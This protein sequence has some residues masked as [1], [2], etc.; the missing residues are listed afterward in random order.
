MHDRLSQESVLEL[1]SLLR[2]ME[3]ARRERG[4]GGDGD[5]GEGGDSSSSC[6]HSKVSALDIPDVI[7]P[8]HSDGSRGKESLAATVS[9]MNSDPRGRRVKAVSA[10]PDL[11]EFRKQQQS[12]R[13]AKEVRF[14]ESR[15]LA[16]PLLDKDEDIDVQTPPPSSRTDPSQRVGGRGRQGGSSN[17]SSSSGSEG[18]SVPDVELF[19]KIP[20]S[21]GVTRTILTGDPSSE[22]HPPPSASPIPTPIHSLPNGGAEM[23]SQD[24]TRDVSPLLVIGGDCSN[25]DLDREDKERE[26]ESVRVRSRKALTVVVRENS[27]SPPQFCKVEQRVAFASS[28]YSD[29]MTSA[30]QTSTGSVP[31]GQRQGGNVNWSAVETLLDRDDAVSAFSIVVERGELEDLARVMQLLGPRPHV[32]TQLFCS[33]FRNSSTSHA[34]DLSISVKQFTNSLSVSLVLGLHSCSQCR[35]GTVFTTASRLC[36][37]NHMYWMTGA[38]T[39]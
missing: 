26:A 14:F 25:P 39:S 13:R 15:G 31:C 5:R 17:S 36:L 18:V 3:N 4:G 1:S 22:A 19:Q 12:L 23:T 6:R 9:I 27:E 7:S 34:V 11:L 8:K 33:F 32:R 30:T 38:A 28:V 21:K 24:E 2:S 37:R 10:R 20:N 35:L 16:D 29:T